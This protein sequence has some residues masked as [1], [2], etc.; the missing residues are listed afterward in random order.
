[1]TVDSSYNSVTGHPMSFWGSQLLKNSHSLTSF[2]SLGSTGAWP[3]YCAATVSCS[4]NMEFHVC[5]CA[6]NFGHTTIDPPPDNHLAISLASTALVPML[7]APLEWPCWALPSSPLG[8]MLCISKC[9]IFVNF[10]MISP[11]EQAPTLPFH[12]LSSL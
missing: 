10:H 7:C 5:M 3:F 9:G 12:S 1:M 2:V 8:C 4:T 6:S 11:A